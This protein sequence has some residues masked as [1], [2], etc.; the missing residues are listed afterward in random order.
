MI[1]KRRIS[2]AT[3]GAAARTASCAER[4]TRRSQLCRQHGQAAA[5]AS[6]SAVAISRL[7]YAARDLVASSEHDTARY[8]CA[9]SEVR[10][11]R[12]AR[13]RLFRFQ[14]IPISVSGRTGA[15]DGWDARSKHAAAAFVHPRASK[16]FRTR[17]RSVPS[18]GNDVR[19]EPPRS[20]AEHTLR[21][22]NQLRR[23][24]NCKETLLAALSSHHERHARSCNWLGLTLMPMAVI[25]TTTTATNISFSTMKAMRVQFCPSRSARRGSRL[26]SLRLLLVPSAALRTS[27]WANNYRYRARWPWSTC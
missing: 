3:T 8:E 1:A 7:H 13:S 2:A 25:P 22:T 23:R 21:S 10:N 11:S 4:R 17:S 27:P 16:N 6:S 26:R 18:H 14:A 9:S 15:A 19:H 5:S 20:S 24:V 12:M